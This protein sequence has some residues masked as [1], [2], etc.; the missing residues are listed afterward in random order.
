[1]LPLEAN[2]C[3][4]EAVMAGQRSMGYEE[5]E[6]SGVKDAASGPVAT[7]TAAAAGV[8]VCTVGRSGQGNLVW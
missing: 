3:V 2:A 5:V 4:A 8:W 6:A 1:M 7:A